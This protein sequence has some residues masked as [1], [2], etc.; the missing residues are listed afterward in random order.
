[1]AY[2]LFGILNSSILQCQATLRVHNAILT[3]WRGFHIQVLTTNSQKITL[4]N[5]LK[6]ASIVFVGQ[7]SQIAKDWFALVMTLSSAYMNAL[8]FI[9]AWDL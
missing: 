2:W 6:I 4:E 1:M 8:A 5:C 7:S 3:H 9:Q